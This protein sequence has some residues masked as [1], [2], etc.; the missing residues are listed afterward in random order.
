M[1]D[2]I[3]IEIPKGIF[4]TIHATMFRHL[5]AGMPWLQTGS[6]KRMSATSAI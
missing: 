4:D 5:M 3:R 6:M 1:S 2:D